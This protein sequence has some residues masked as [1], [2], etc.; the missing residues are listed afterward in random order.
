MENCGFW[1]AIDAVYRFCSEQ[2]HLPDVCGKECHRGSYPVTFLGGGV[3]GAL[4]ESFTSVS[5]IGLALGMLLP[6]FYGIPFGIG[7]IVRLYTDRKYG[8]EFFK[9]KGMLAA[10]GLIAGGIITQVIMSIVLVMSGL[11]G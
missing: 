7:G 8:K 6:P 11:M 5:F 4:L 10:S 3:I 2:T 1:H 9:E